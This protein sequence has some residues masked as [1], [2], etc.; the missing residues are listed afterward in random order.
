[1]S[2]LTTHSKILH[3]PRYPMKRIVFDHNEVYA[4]GLWFPTIADFLGFMHEI[5]R[6]ES[7]R[8]ITRETTERDQ[9]SEQQSADMRERPG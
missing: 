1:M 6:I 9:S 4:F 3:P 5:E 7:G 8:R 2:Q